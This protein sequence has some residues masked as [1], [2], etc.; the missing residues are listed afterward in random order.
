MVHHLVHP[1]PAGEAALDT[2]ATQEPTGSGE[3]EQ[4]HNSVRPQESLEESGS[5][6]SSRVLERIVSTLNI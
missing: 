5:T 6:G 4:G 2:G 1:L 3:T